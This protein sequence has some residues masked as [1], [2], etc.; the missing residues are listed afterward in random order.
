MSPPL[1]QI[2]LF[3]SLLPGV[4]VRAQDALTEEQKIRHVLNR[5]GYGARPGDAERVRQ[6]G[7]SAYIDSQLHP[8]SMEDAEVEKRL[9][10][11]PMLHMDFGELLAFDQPPTPVAIRRRATVLERGMDADMARAAAQDAS[12]RARVQSAVTNMMV[13]AL[14]ARPNQP[15]HDGLLFQTRILR[16]VYSERQLHELLVDFWMNHFNVFVGDPYLRT[17]FEEHVVRPRTLGRFH[18]L[19]LAT[20]KHPAMLLYLDN[21][22]ST[23]P[24]AEVQP[25]ITAAAGASDLV[26]GQLVLR[27]RQLYFETAKGLNENYARELMELHTLGVDGGYTQQDVIEVARAFTGWTIDGSADRQDG[28]FVFDAALHLQGDK[29]VLGKTIRSGGMDEGLAILD[30]LA[31]HP[32]TARFISTKLIRRFVADDP[33]EALVD[34]AA[35]TFLESDGDIRAVLRTI[36]SSAEFWSPLAFESKVK[37][38]IEMVAS[39][40]RAL[41]ADID[42]RFENAT[43]QLSQALNRMGERMYGRESP[44]GYPDVAPAWVS[45]NALFQRLKFSLELTT[46]RIDGIRVDAEAALPM[47]LGLGYPEVTEQQILAAR[48]IMNAPV[49]GAQGGRMMT[50]PSMNMMQGAGARRAGAGTEIAPGI[51]AVAILLGSPDFQKR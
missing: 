30:M 25:R 41:G 35:R 28:N 49:E 37:K 17:S 4:P 36:F 42:T 2:L 22:L 33:P 18:D 3:L 8:E 24:E 6:M 19:L 43:G 32:S 20:A 45:T 23:A 50:D 14:V 9:A 27:S 21:W 5:L 34:A 26:Q 48:E 38:P 44:D 31:R 47:F 7:L 29:T 40:L 16:A 1:A 11:Y 12:H 39:A 15:A 10:M 13:P 46:G 51:L